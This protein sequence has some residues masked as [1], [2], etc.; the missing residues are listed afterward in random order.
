[1][2]RWQTGLGRAILL[3]LLLAGLLAY[4]EETYRLRYRLATGYSQKYAATVKGK[5]SLELGG[6]K[7]ELAVDGN[8]TLQEKCL[9][10]YENDSRLIEVKL[11]G[12]KVSVSAGQ[13]PFELDERRLVLARDS[14]GK[15]TEVK[16]SQGFGGPAGSLPLDLGALTSGLSQATCFPQ[17]SLPVGG[18]WSTKQKIPIDD[19]TEV[20]ISAD[21]VLKAVARDGKRQV[22]VID[23]KISVPLELPV[24]SMKFRISGKL[25]ANLRSYVYVDNGALMKASCHAA[26]NVIAYTEEG[27]ARKVV[28]RLQLPDLVADIAQTK[29]SD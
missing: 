16:E 20:V 26:A 17:Q 9:G 2:C 15:I 8:M 6:E 7:Q 19:D 4:A 5:G 1:M 12:G 22:A 28:G 13:P 3:L 11:L 29:A 23:S 21:S 10:T 27:G 24:R 14:Y 25:V 18:S